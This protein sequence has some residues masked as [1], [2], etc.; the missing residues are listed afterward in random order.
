[1]RYH[2]HTPGDVR[3]MLDVCGVS[4]IAEL[5]RSIPENLRLGRLLDVPA[6]VDEVSLFSEFQRLAARNRTEHPP[7]VGAGAYAHHVPPVVD[8]LLLRGEFFTAYTPYQPESPRGRSRPS[9]SGR[10][11]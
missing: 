3:Q 4:S 7:F 1:M 10:P 2:P 8:Q 9:S 5:F 11:S 6:A